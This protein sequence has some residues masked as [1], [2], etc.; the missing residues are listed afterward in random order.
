MLST[1]I[2]IGAIAF[3]V[4]GGVSIGVGATMAANKVHK[5]EDDENRKLTVSEKI[6]VSWPFFLPG[7][8]F[9]AAAEFCICKNIVH[10]EKVI[11]RLSASAK[12]GIESAAATSDAVKKICGPKKAEEVEREV[13]SNKVNKTKIPKKNLS[14][15]QVI[16]C[17]Y[18]KGMDDDLLERSYYIATPQ[19]HQ[20]NILR[21]VGCGI[22]K[23]GGD[24]TS[25]FSVHDLLDHTS[26]KSIPD[27]DWKGWNISDGIPEFAKEGDFSLTK[28]GKKLYGVRFDRPPV[29]IL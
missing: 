19:E 12:A 22:Q 23:D 26:G 14:D 4:L 3:G 11:R 27:D 2:K 29:D 28:D 24:G 25:V 1:L 10:T 5:I 15:D 21:W 6:K 9:I 18:W 20:Q 7:I 16:C 13:F 17:V 8:G